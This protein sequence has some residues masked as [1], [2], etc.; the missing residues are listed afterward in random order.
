MPAFIRSLFDQVKQ[1]TIVEKG[2][3]AARIASET[4]SLVKKDFNKTEGENVEVIYKNVLM[5]V[6]K[7]DDVQ[8]SARLD[9][10]V[11]EAAGKIS[12]DAA[13]KLS[14]KVR[15]FN[16]T[17]KSVKSALEPVK[18]YVTST[19]A[20]LQQLIVNAYGTVRKVVQNFIATIRDHSKT[21]FE[22]GQSYAGQ[23]KNYLLAFDCVK[24]I[25]ANLTTLKKTVDTQANFA[26][27]TTKKNI[28]SAADNTSLIKNTLQESY[29]TNKSIFS[30]LI[31]SN[32][33]IISAFFSKF[34]VELFYSPEKSVK[35]IESVKDLATKVKVSSEN[36]AENIR[37][38]SKK[39]KKAKAN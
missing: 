32:V 7:I 10:K 38:N 30:S 6:K 28:Q 9:Y 37:P 1:L 25:C 4:F 35:V 33:S 2:L 39:A 36:L 31:S 27:T 11:V 22:I 17:I 13:K 21:L 34:D 16:N 24:L 23:V 15:K 14:E 19:S 20:S 3:E 29:S 5:S 12:R 8:A 26:L 18:K